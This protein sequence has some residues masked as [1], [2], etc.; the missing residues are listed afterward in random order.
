MTDLLTPERVR[1]W[2]QRND[3]LRDGVWFN[4]I[5]DHLCR[6]YLTLWERNKELEALI[7]RR[8]IQRV[9]GTDTG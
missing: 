7:P 2:Q 8:L 3:S 5:I 9:G 4:E 1:E 6:D